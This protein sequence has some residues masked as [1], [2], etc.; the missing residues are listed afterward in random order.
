MILQ[1]VLSV[2]SNSV[3]NEKLF[4]VPET[5]TFFPLFMNELLNFI[6]YLQLTMTLVLF[7]VSFNQINEVLEIYSRLFS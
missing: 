7:I 5:T 4:S 6:M 2:K 1:T 3:N